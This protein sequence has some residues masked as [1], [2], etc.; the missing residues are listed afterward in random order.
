MDNTPSPQDFDKGPLEKSVED[1]LNPST[2]S[3]GAVLLLPSS[4]LQIAVKGKQAKNKFLSAIDLTNTLRWSAPDIE[5]PPV[6]YKI[7]RNKALTDLVTS[8]PAKKT[9]VF[10]D[11]NR[12]K[13]A[14]YN[15]YLV[16]VM[17]NGQ[18]IVVNHIKIP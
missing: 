6:G 9:M 16:A 11:H 18:E 10:E 7:Y 4:P 13:H 3:L 17:E 5:T 12:K 2:T 1:L 8:V 15:Y 14:T